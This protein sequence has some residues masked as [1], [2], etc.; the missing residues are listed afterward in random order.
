MSQLPKRTEQRRKVQSTT[1][2]TTSAP[3]DG[4]AGGGRRAQPREARK[5][6]RKLVGDAVMPPPNKQRARTRHQSLFATPPHH[7][8]DCSII[9]DTCHVLTMAFAVPTTPDSQ[10]CSHGD[11]SRGSRSRIQLKSST[12][13]LRSGKIV[14][15]VDLF[16]LDDSRPSSFRGQDTTGNGPFLMRSPNLLSLH[17][18]RLASQSSHQ[19]KAA[20]HATSPA[21]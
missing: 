6:S 13:G 8:L 2:C 21:A 18:L 16:Y 9:F 11:G 10:Q 15:G 7:T 5:G 4:S 14:P 19:L 1:S 12:S 3:H 17:C 20:G